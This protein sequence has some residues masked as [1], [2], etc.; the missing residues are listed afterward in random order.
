MSTDKSRGTVNIDPEV[1]KQLKVYAAENDTTVK[2]LVE[3][4]I[5]SYITRWPKLGTAASRSARP[6]SG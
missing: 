6:R 2:N 3:R 1:L 5:L 4:A